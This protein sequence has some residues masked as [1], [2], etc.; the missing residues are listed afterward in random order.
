MSPAMMP[1]ASGNPHEPANASSSSDIANPDEWTQTP[2]NVSVG[3]PLCTL[4]IAPNT[5]GLSTQTN[6]SSRMASWDSSLRR[7]TE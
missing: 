1:A 6:A 3:L 4:R 7:S 5:N 2:Y